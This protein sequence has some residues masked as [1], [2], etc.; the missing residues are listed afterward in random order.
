MNTDIWVAF[1]VAFG[2][3]FAAVISVVLTARYKNNRINQNNES[4]PLE[5]R[6]AINGNWEGE[7]DQDPGKKP[8]ITNYP[9]FIRLNADERTIDGEMRWKVPVDGKD[10]E[11]YFSIQNGQFF[12]GRFLRLNYTPDDKA[13]VQFGTLIL[14]LNETGNSMD[15][16]QAGYGKTTGD[17]VKG[18]LKIDK[19]K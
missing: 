19:A 17:V 8:E 7:I 11:F 15:G 5:R 1:I 9:V 13:T 16:K 2:V 18:S 12:H 4:I 6:K 10:T 14:K 3:I